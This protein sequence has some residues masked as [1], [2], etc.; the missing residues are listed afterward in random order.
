[1]PKLLRVPTEE[2]QDDY[3]QNVLIPNVYNDIIKQLKKDSE[4]SKRLD[5][6][7]EEL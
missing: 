3:E 6:E 5:K 7:N 2:E 1:M 4:I